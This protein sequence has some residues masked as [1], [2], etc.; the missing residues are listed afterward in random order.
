VV[1]TIITLDTIQI[2]TRHLILVFYQGQYRIAQ[3]G[4]LDGY[5]DEQGLKILAFLS[6]SHNISRLS[7][8]LEANLVHEAS[9]EEIRYYEEELQRLKD[10]LRQELRK[11][12][13]GCHVWDNLHAVRFNLSEY[14]TSPLSVFTSSDILHMVVKASKDKPISVKLDLEQLGNYTSIEYIYVIDLDKKRF[15]IYSGFVSLEEDCHFGRFDDFEVVKRSDWAPD[16]IITNFNISLYG[17]SFSQ[18]ADLKSR[19]E[20]RMKAMSS[21]REMIS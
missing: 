1:Q 11:H 21:K 3:Y 16:F 19:K 9:E 7:K 5:I 4:Q 13:Y 8:V 12:R 14:S 15:E 18:I 2:G 10:I 6:E 17:P 20:T